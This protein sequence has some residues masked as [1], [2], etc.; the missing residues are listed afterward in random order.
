M[1]ESFE[2]KQDQL[3]TVNSHLNVLSMRDPLSNLLN[4]RALEAALQEAWRDTQRQQIPLALMM[5]DIDRFK[6]FNDRYGH[7]EG[8]DC[9]RRIG[10]VLNTLAAN[11][12]GVAARYGGEEFAFVL[13][14]T[15]AKDAL[16]IGEV[17]RLAIQG[18]GPAHQN[19]SAGVVTASIGLKMSNAHG[20]NRIEKLIAGPDQNLYSAKHQGR[21]L[22][23]NDARFR[24]VVT[25]K[26]AS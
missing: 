26:L 10:A 13:P 4:R 5:I 6:Q 25:E 11:Y 12:S 21:N 14:H 16:E 2:T 17:V 7:L 8:D 22:V 18:L 9:L 23:V 1:A 3:E 24:T 20:V 15:S 19:N